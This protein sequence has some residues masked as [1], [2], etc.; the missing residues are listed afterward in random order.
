MFSSKFYML[1]LSTEL[2]DLSSQSL[3]STEAWF[4]VIHS[5]CDSWCQFFN[6]HI[7][8]ECS[9]SG[10]YFLGSNEIRRTLSV[11]IYFMISCS[12]QL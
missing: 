2:T 9:I 6:C 7:R 12:A 5:L 10:T 3:S 11:S 4:P 8:Y 1:C